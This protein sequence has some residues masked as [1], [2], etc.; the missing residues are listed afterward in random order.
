M[1]SVILL[2]MAQ[3]AAKGTKLYAGPAGA[4]E[5]AQDLD[6]ITAV[7]AGPEGGLAFDGRPAV[8][9]NCALRRDDEP[10]RS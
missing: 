9:A 4:A 1:G 6:G 2:K 5:N 8:V 3:K 10:N 7:N